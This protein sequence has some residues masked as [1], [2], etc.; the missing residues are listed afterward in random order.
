MLACKI[1]SKHCKADSQFCIIVCSNDFKLLSS[2]RYCVN[3]VEKGNGT[4]NSTNDTEAHNRRG[5]VEDTKVYDE[6]TWAC[7]CD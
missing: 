2:T 1:A 4:D 5:G 7:P 6:S 3:K